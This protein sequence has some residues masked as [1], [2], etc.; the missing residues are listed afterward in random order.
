M[1]A[2]SIYQFNYIVSSGFYKPNTNNMPV[3]IQL[4][5]SGALWLKCFN[6]DLSKWLLGNRTDLILF[7]LNSAKGI[8]EKEK[9]TNI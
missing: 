8:G 7:L 1:N 5:I 4:T 6:H 2:S 3:I 9:G